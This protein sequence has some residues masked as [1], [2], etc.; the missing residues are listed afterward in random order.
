MNNVFTKIVHVLAVVLVVVL[1]A[2]VAMMFLPSLTVTPKKSKVNPNPQPTDFSFM[3][4]WWTATEDVS[5]GLVQI[6]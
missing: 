2:Q 6:I 4:Y 3:D 1:L 5:D